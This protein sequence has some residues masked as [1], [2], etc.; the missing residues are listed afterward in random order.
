MGVWE[1]GVATDPG[2][3][4]EGLIADLL[5]RWGAFIE[6]HTPYSTHNS[7]L[8]LS[9]G[10]G[11]DEKCLSGLS[12]E[13]GPACLGTGLGSTRKTAFGSFSLDLETLPLG[14]L[15]WIPQIGCPCSQPPFQWVLCVRWGR[16]AVSLLMG[17]G[18]VGAP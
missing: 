5:L 13:G 2:Q 8:G 16:V 7:N 6:F 9:L 12:R 10:S 15:G 14:K 1:V 3:G 17:P 4:L 11:A 18:L